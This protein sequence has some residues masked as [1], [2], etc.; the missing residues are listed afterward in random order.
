MYLQKGLYSIP[1]TVQERYL[2][3]GNI[4]NVKPR[5]GVL[6]GLTI[7]E[8]FEAINYI[9]QTPPSYQNQDIIGVPFY[10]LFLDLLNTSYGQTFFSNKEVNIYLK[11]VLD[12]YGRMLKS[13]KSLKYLTTADNGW[14][15]PNGRKRIN[16]DDFV[17]DTNL[18]HFG[19]DSWNSW[20]TRALR[21]NV[22]PV[23]P[24]PDV[25]VHNS[26]A[27]PLTSTPVPFYG[28]KETDEFWL[29]NGCYSLIEMFA[30]SEYGLE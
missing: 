12:D 25:I 17:C 19:F 9:V 5:S 15:G 1:E 2:D 6:Y 4:I 3:Q 30:A 23:D 11:D 27:F 16:Y 8:L 29:K 21:P 20:F 26:E 14:L 13:N 28:V 22:R 18:P 24:N 10:S 7:N